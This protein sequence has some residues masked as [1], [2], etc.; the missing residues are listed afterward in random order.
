M[1]YKYSP[2]EAHSKEARMRAYVRWNDINH[3]PFEV[4]LLDCRVNDLIFNDNGEQ[5][6]KGVLHTLTDS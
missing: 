4:F 1:G 3:A 5:L 6:V 2:I